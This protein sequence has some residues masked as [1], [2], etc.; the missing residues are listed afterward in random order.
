MPVPPAPSAPPRLEGRHVLFEPVVPGALDPAARGLFVAASERIARGADP[1]AALAASLA[2]LGAGA[3]TAW[4]V[5]PRGGPPVG[6]AWLTAAVRAAG[7]ASQGLPVAVAGL[8][9]PSR[10]AAHEAALNEALLLLLGYAF[11]TRACHAATVRAAPW[12]RRSS[13]PV[14]ILA[15]EWPFLRASLSARAAR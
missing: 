3:C 6:L 12:T 2:A 5:A 8:S 13:R 11:E 14:P 9:W 7:D 10:P 1:E 15:S 4:T